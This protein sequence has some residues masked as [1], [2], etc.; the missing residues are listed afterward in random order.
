MQRGGGG[1]EIYNTW[2]HV[3]RQQGTPVV[4][5]PAAR[6]PLLVFVPLPFMPPAK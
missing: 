1:R 5:T 4:G 2:D 6:T 3:D